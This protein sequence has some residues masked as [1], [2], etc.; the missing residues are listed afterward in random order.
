V[1]FS[2]LF[3]DTEKSKAQ[4]FEPNVLTADKVKMIDLGLHNAASDLMWL[5]AIQYLGGAGSKGS[6]KLGDYLFAST[7]LD[8]Q[9][10]YPYAFGVLMLPMFGSPDK[11]IEL[12]KK[13]LKDAEPDWR[14]PYY[15][16]ATYHS[17]MDNPVEATKYFDIAANTKGA[18]DNIKWVAANYGTRPDKRERTKN[19]WIG[20]MSTTDD[21]VV[22]ERAK[23]YVMHYEIIDLLEN[24][25]KAYHEKNKK[26]PDNLEALITS[27]ILRA[28]PPDPFGSIFKVDGN[29]RVTAE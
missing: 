17:E 7:E 18:P 22:R 24:A 14:I 20:I 23:N 15:M 4:S 11:A 10:S 2:Q 3:F 27:N 5:A 8:S 9:F 25:A 19:I 12:G 6:P 29:G 26:Y 16:A 13:G 28:I 1:I 21:E